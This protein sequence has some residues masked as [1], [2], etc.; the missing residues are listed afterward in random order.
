[1]QLWYAPTSPFS[2]KVRIAAY[3]LGQTQRIELI[4]VNPWSDQRLRGL[5]PLSK[6]PTLILETGEALFE[7][8]V[9]CDYLDSLVPARRLYPSEGYK[10]WGALLLQGL[11][12]GASTSA[13]RLYAD[14]QRPEN[15]RSPS[16][17]QR[18]RL[19]I[20]ASL[21]MLEGHQ[22][23]AEGFTI[24][25][26]SV[27]AFLGYL[28]FRWPEKDWCA[29]RPEI[30]AWFRDFSERPSMTTTQHKVARV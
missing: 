30:D 7:S 18:F 21:T 3:E 29:S 8:A 9:V 11:A 20:D 12:D 10:R 25:H 17:M 16:M 23:L 27:A 15:E 2:R 28:K 14:E 6:V 13:G 24:G 26:V 22:H 1:M 5:N 19:A 4:E